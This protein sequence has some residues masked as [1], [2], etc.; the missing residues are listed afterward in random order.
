MAEGNAA[1]SSHSLPSDAAAEVRAA[2]VTIEATKRD[3][4]AM[5]AD[6]TAAIAAGELLQGTKGILEVLQVEVRSERS[7]GAQHTKDIIEITETDQNVNETA[8]LALQGAEEA[9]AAIDKIKRDAAA[10]RDTAIVNSK[11]IDN[12]RRNVKAAWSDI[13]SLRNDLKKIEAAAEVSPQSLQRLRP[14]T[15]ANVKTANSHAKAASQRAATAQGAADEAE[16]DAAALRRELQVAQAQVETHAAAVQTVKREAAD[17]P[18]QAAAAGGAVKLPQQRIAAVK[19]ENERRYNVLQRA[20]DTAQAAQQ[21]EAERVRAQF[22]AAHSAKEDWQAA[23][24]VE[25][26]SSRGMQAELGKAPVANTSI[27]QASMH[28]SAGFAELVQE[29]RKAALTARSEADEAEL[30][31]SSLEQ[32]QSLHR[33]AQQDAMGRQTNA[34]CRSS[35]SYWDQGLGFICRYR[36]KLLRTR[37]IATVGR[38]YMIVTLDAV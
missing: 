31:S 7:R 1:G 10:T 12:T 32:M 22:Q 28:D 24:A 3:V 17:A 34:R 36:R 23:V 11:S 5:S 6:G 15:H 37:Q 38:V 30:M 8:T 18:Q 2:N 20:S 9:T 16:T 21:A 27:G 14:D 4:A 29:A 25:V 33:P 13:T 35:V 26:E 19:Q